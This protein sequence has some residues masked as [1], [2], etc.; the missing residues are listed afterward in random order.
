MGNDNLKKTLVCLFFSVIPAFALG[1]MGTFFD[2]YIRKFVASETLVFVSECKY[3]NG[4]AALIM[5]V[6]VKEGLLVEYDKGAVVN[7][8]TV[9]TGRGKVLVTETHGGAYSYRRAQALVS[10]LATHSFELRPSDELGKLK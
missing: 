10:E 3:E 6:G 9:S 8:G 4:K 2:E 7:L 1:D 5:P